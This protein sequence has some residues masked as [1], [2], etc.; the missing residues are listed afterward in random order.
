MK[1]DRRGVITFTHADTPSQAGSFA[2]V[3]R[4][5]P[6]VTSDAPVTL[7]WYESD[8]YC[9]GRDRSRRRKA[10]ADGAGELQARDALRA[11]LVNGEK[12]WE[13]DVL[14]R[15]PSQ[16][17]RASE[18]RILRRSCA[19]RAV[20]ARSRSASGSPGIGEHPSHRCFLRHRRCDH[21]PAARPG[22]GSPS[23]PGLSRATRAPWFTRRI[24]RRATTH[25][26]NAGRFAIAFSLRDEHTGR[27]RVR[28]L[29]GRQG[30][31]DGRSADDHRLQAVTPLVRL[32]PG[33]PLRIGRLPSATRR[34]GSRG[35]RD[36]RAPA[37]K[38]GRGRGSPADG[39]AGA[40]RVRFQVT[41]PETGHR[42]HW[43]GG[44]PGHS[45]PGP[46]PPA[47]GSGARARLRWKALPVQTRH[48]RANERHHE[49]AP[50]RLPA[51]VPAAATAS[52][53]RPARAFARACAR[54]LEVS[55]PM[56]L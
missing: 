5:I 30:W 43:R 4:T 24:R 44:S 56:A 6:V 8:T 2:Q 54:R 7:R 31:P 25:S 16:R 19:R 48:H 14:G 32:T 13:E 47:P 41:V 46:P 18:R 33:T 42:A 51:T 40:K 37:G 35:G 23:Q 28:V 29:A 26:G 38:A 27:S 11:V 22:G 15:N 50:G 3:T 12:V 34:W 53:S 9:G 20:A 52:P 36:S 39:G 17:G 21:R 10:R 45:L 55:R 1:T 49:D